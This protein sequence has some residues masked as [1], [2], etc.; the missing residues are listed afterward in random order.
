MKL[1]IAVSVAAS[2]CALFLA[3]AVQAQSGKSYST[4]GAD[5]SAADA[6]STRTPAPDPVAEGVR[7]RFADR[8][9]GMDVTAVQRTPYGLF[10][11]QL[12]MELVYTD[13]DVRWV[14]QGTLVDAMTRR[15]VTAERQEKLGEVP[16]A[17]LPLD[18]AVKQVRGNGK[19]R[20]AIFE[21]PNCGYCKQLHKTL[22]TLDDVTIYTFLYPILAPDSSVKSRDIW[23]SSDPARAWNDWMIRGKT[24]AS[25]SCDTPTEQVLA[26]G[27]R[28]MVRGTPTM[29]FEDGSRVSGAMPLDQFQARLDGKR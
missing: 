4:S 19:R 26:L 27:K 1:R 15:N 5:K 16:L 8:F 23:C 24:P 21:D 29:F 3:G 20:V 10:E 9:P 17:E 14:M 28:L 2:L 6:K 13:E 7:K 25:K 12:G 22:E 11:V 18:L